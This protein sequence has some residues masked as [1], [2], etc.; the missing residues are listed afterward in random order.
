MALCAIV[1]LATAGAKAGTPVVV[2]LY[3]SQG[4]SSCPPADA[5][6]AKL[7]RRKDIVAMSLPVTYWDMLGWKDTLAGEANTRRQK[8]YASAM[9][10]GGVYTPQIVVDG[11][12]DIV[13]SRTDDVEAAIERELRRPN[14]G[15]NLGLRR[16][17]NDV[18]LTIDAVP[19]GHGRE[20]PDATIWLFQLRASTTVKIG[21]GENAGRSLTYTN[22]VSDIRD[23]GHWDGAA[24]SRVL[25]ADN[26]KS[27]PHD[28]IA[29]VL[30][31]HG[32]GRVIAAAYLGKNDYY[33]GQ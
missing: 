28:A 32:Y 5:L 13:G 6:L 21:G 26:A 22:V 27:S 12:S 4:C 33:V 17:L 20:E 25:P 3:T 15:I 14:D 7:A 9:G 23:L 11:V 16:E 19:R 8:S 24:L 30:Q 31:Q 1:A 18:R 10:H 2:E 29:V